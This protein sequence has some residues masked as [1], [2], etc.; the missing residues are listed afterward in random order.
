MADGDR[1]DSVS[2]L[3]DDLANLLEFAGDP[4]SLTCDPPRLTSNEVD[5][6]LREALSQSRAVEGPQ[7]TSVTPAPPSSRASWP[8]PGIAQ[9]AWWARDDGPRDETARR[10]L[11]PVVTH[12]AG[13]PRFSR[14]KAPPDSTPEF[15]GGDT[16][17]LRGRLKRQG[18]LWFSSGLGYYLTS[19]LGKA[20]DQYPA[21]PGQPPSAVR[22]FPSAE[23]GSVPKVARAARAAKAAA[24]YLVDVTAPLLAAH[25]KTIF[26]CGAEPGLVDLTLHAHHPGVCSDRAKYFSVP[27]HATKI[28]G[29]PSLSVPGDKSCPMCVGDLDA[30]PTG[31]AR[32]QG[33]G[34]SVSRCAECRRGDTEVVL[35]YIPLDDGVY[36]TPAFRTAKPDV[37]RRPEKAAAGCLLLAIDWP[38]AALVA[39]EATEEASE[40]ATG[41]S[42]ARRVLRFAFR[43]PRGAVAPL[44]EP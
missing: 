5:A 44:R 7:Q 42:M 8:Q 23:D 27:D 31:R 40:E 30:A 35:G 2:N 6:F 24:G 33:R 14:F 3:E 20:F 12:V 4:T 25:L 13:C 22:L 34:A 28:L 17:M 10:A 19:L 32:A 37:W 15:H 38:H 21:E 39:P 11:T 18:F 29:P 41:E 26:K 16:D 1:D 43:V 9:R 36:G